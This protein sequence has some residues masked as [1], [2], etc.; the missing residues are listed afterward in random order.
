MWFAFGPLA[1]FMLLLTRPRNL[2]PES[3]ARY[4]IY[5]FLPVVFFFSGAFLDIGLSRSWE[6]RSGVAPTDGL[7]ATL[8]AGVLL[9][10]LGE[11][12]HPRH[13]RR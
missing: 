1:G 7:L 10:G 12:V 4:W 11:I 3:P 6:V 13:G 9:L 2:K 5:I 8:R